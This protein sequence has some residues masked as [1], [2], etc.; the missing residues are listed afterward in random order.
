MEFAKELAGGS[1]LL[2]TGCKLG[3]E[4]KCDLTFQKFLGELFQT[5][6]EEATMAFDLRSNPFV[7]SKTN[8]AISTAAGTFSSCLDM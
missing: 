6:Y 5:L 3:K 4:V 1:H 2:I 8:I 7:M